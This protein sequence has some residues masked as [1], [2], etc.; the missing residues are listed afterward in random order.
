GPSAMI[1]SSSLSAQYC[2]NCSS[3]FYK[4]TLLTDV[5]PEALI[6]REENFGPVAAVTTFDSEEEVIARANDTEYGL[7]AYIVT[8]NGARQM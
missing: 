3:L 6:M 5:P 7:V 8:E 1:I 2:E 4:P